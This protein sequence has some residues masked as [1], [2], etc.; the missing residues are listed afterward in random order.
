MRNYKEFTLDN[1]SYKADI[2]NNFYAIA[3]NKIMRF[4]AD[5]LRLKRDKDTGIYI[6]EEIDATCIEGKKEGQSFYFM[7]ESEI[8][9]TKSDL[10]SDLN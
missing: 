10:M 4:Q 5:S 8:Y 9:M 7:D 2:I 3:C 6:I 1:I